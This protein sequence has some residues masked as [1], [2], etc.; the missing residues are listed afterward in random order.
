MQLE[1]AMDESREVA[2]DS[3]IL[4]AH[5]LLP[6]LGYL[7]GNAFLIKGTEP[8]LV[9][10]GVAPLREEFLKAL[11]SHIDPSAIR[12]IWLT[13]TDT[14][15]IGNLAAVCALAPQAR[16]VTSFLGLGKLIIS[17]LPTDS[18]H[19]LEPGAVLDV[20]DRVLQPLRPPYF[21]APE[22]TGVFDPSTRVFYSADCFGALLKEPVS[23]ARTLSADSLRSGLVA[24]SSL[25][26]PWLT[27]VDPERFSRSLDEVARL[28]P[29]TILSAHLPPAPGLTDSLLSIV[30]ET[31]V[32]RRSP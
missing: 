14:D 5:V 11:R 3:F 27:L 8:V 18:I 2:E 10:T 21:D 32:D 20:G 13:H 26:S 7:T 30:R 1:L 19:M 31:Y 23:D 22:T 25:D 17:E 15:H 6:G 4:P 12:W 9:D 29:E 16:V 24:W 28:A